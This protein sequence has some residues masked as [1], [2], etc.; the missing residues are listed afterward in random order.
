MQDAIAATFD[1][2]AA[3]H[4]A[5]PI[6]RGLHRV[7]DCKRSA[8]NEKEM[9]EFLRSSQLAKCLD[10]TGEFTRVDVA[11]GRIGKRGD[12]QG[13][14]KS[15]V[16]HFWMFVSDLHCGEVAVTIDV[17]FS[18]ERVDNGRTAR[19]FEIDHQVKAIYQ[20]IFLENRENLVG[21]HCYFGHIAIRS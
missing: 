3:I 11:V 2:M 13:F 10:E 16:L 9:A 7:L 1:A 14:L 12:E 21:G 5:L 6:E 18:L 20:D 19:L 15:L 17:F 4:L 8:G